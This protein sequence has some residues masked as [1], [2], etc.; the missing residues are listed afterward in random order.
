V[1]IKSH[2]VRQGSTALDAV[3]DQLDKEK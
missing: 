2:Y 1:P 3:E